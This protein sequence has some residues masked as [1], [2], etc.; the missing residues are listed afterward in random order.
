MS[1]PAPAPGPARPRRPGGSGG[2]VRLTTLGKIIAGGVAVVLVVVAITFVSSGD[3]TPA[4][5]TPKPFGASSKTPPSETPSPKPADT[6]APLPLWVGP[7]PINPDYPGLTT[8]RGN[9]TRNFFGVGPVPMAPK[10]KWREGPWC[11][12]STDLGE[13]ST[14]CGTG[15]NGQPNVIPIGGDRVEVRVGGYDY[16]YHFLD[17]HTGKQTRPSFKT[18][19]LAKGSATSDPDGCPL[20]YV[21]SRDDDFRILALDTKKPREVWSMNSQSSVPNPEWNSDWDGAAQIVGDYMLVG[22]ENSWFY[23]VELNKQCNGNSVRVNPHIVFSTPGWD[24]QLLH[25]LQ[26]DQD[27]GDISIENSVAYDDKRKV[28]YFGNGG[29]LVQGYNISKILNGG[30]GATRVFRYWMGGENDASIVIADDGDIIA[31]SHLGDAEYSYGQARKSGQLVRLDPKKKGNPVVWKIRELGGSEAGFFSTPALVDDVLYATSNSGELMAIDADTG[32]KLWTK[33]FSSHMWSG[34]AVV[35]G[36]LVVGDCGS[37]TLFAFDVS[38]PKRPPK[39]LWQLKLGGCIESTPAIWDGWIYV[40]TRSGFL[41]GISDKH[42]AM[43]YRNYAKEHGGTV[44]DPAMAAPASPSPD[45]DAGP[46][47]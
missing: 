8:L 3:D 6:G 31:S 4:A 42:P 37:G 20:Y 38:D 30:Q 24:G 2:A 47:G 7:G 43:M 17:G 46:F 23:I 35:D 10:V 36:T 16:D 26:G 45:P 40:G 28:A 41:F 25:D 19:D 27:P 39:Q 9:W 22:G 13:T 44:S 34:P 12:T 15:W 21:G 29:G 18:G 32:K 14:W 33:R 1:E 11:G 5:R